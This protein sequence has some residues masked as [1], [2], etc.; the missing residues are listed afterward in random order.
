M[1]LSKYLNL[2]AQY[3]YHEERREFL[4]CSL[5]STLRGK[6]SKWSRGLED[7]VLVNLPTHQERVQYG[8]AGLEGTLQSTAGVPVL[9][10]LVL[11]ADFIETGTRAPM[12]ACD[13]I[14]HP[15]PRPS[16]T[17]FFTTD[18]QTVATCQSELVHQIEVCLPFRS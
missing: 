9:Y 6:E 8:N 3:P 5:S 11:R 1:A 16:L 14:C 10:C 18:S 15:S 12:A 2:R 17:V 13:G 4:T 7:R